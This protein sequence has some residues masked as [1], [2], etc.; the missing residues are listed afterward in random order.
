VVF[1]DEYRGDVRLLTVRF[2]D[3]EPHPVQLVFLLFLLLLLFKSFKVPGFVGEFPTKRRIF[4]GASI[5][6]ARPWP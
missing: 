2:D 3:R 1:G 5:A 4:P 6:T